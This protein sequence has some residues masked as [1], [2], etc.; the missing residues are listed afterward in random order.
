MVLDIDRSKRPRDN[1]IPRLPP[2]HELPCNTSKSYPF[3]R[4]LF[5]RRSRSHFWQIHE[6]HLFPYRPYSPT[7]LPSSAKLA[8][9]LRLGWCP[10]EQEPRPCVPLLRD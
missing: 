8:K 3:T 4:H 5:P 2:G 9:R 10:R 1:P 6:G 7:G